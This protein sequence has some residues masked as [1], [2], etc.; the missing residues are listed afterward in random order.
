MSRNI[1]CIPQNIVNVNKYFQPARCSLL[2]CGCLQYYLQYIVVVFLQLQPEEPVASR[3]F[4]CHPLPKKWNSCSLKS[5][6]I[7]SSTKYINR[8]INLYMI[9]NSEGVLPSLFF[10]S[11]C[12]LCLIWVLES[13]PVLIQV[14]TIRVHRRYNVRFQNIL[15]ATYGHICWYLWW[16]ISITRLTMEFTFIKNIFQDTNVDT[17]FINLVRKQ[18]FFLGLRSKG[19]TT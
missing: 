7:P 6:T 13:R 8:S 11:N 16:V 18:D 15:G 17:I 9:L 1:A 19:V 12:P 10:T 2:G 14:G 5:Q 3:V 4:I